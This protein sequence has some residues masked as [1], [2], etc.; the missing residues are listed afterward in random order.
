MEE[1]RCRMVAAEVEDC[2]SE[3]RFDG[4]MIE[5]EDPRHR[6]LRRRADVEVED[7]RCNS[8]AVEMEDPRCRGLSLKW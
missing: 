3:V 5:A 2:R 7:S 6:S 4:A 8:I 1:H